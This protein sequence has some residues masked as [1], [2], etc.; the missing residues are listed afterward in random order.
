[1]KLKFG[2]FCETAE[3]IVKTTA[4]KLAIDLLLKLLKK[5]ASNAIFLSYMSIPDYR[6]EALVCRDKLTE[7]LTGTDKM[8]KHT[9]LSINQSANINSVF[10]N[11]LFSYDSM[12]T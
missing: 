1:M 6:E 2:Q 11:K 8:P 10:N 5:Y 4:R 9:W 3:D 7:G 12:T